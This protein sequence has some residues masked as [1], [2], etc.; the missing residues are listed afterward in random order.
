MPKACKRFG[1]Y[2]K[3]E[4]GLNGKCVLITGAS[5]GIGC[6]AAL[7]FAKEGA[8]LAL[9]DL[10]WGERTQAVK[11]AIA[12]TGAEVEYIAC[13]VA[14]FDAVEKAVKT[15]HERF[16]SLDVVINNAGITKDGLVMRMKEQD[17]DSVIGVNLKGA[18]NFV[19]H[20]APIMTRQRSGRFINVASIVGVVGN[21]GQANYS[22]SKAG[23]IGLTKTVAKELGSRNITSNAIAPGFIETAMTDALSDKVKAELNSHIS[24]RRLGKAEDVARL[25]VFLASDAGS[26]ISGQVIGV[27]GCMSI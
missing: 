18:F 16:G 21:P 14:D 1:R 25:M 2:Y 3:M 7:A 9:V 15:A 10:D 20:A 19:R 22:A 6:A 26:Y 24:L 11:D 27:D 23:I 17:F 4:L 8:K 12:Q 13:N 5:G